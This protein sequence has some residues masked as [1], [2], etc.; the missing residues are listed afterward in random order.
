M[1]SRNGESFGV[2]RDPPTLQ[3][4]DDS[5]RPSVHCH[6]HSLARLH[7]A[8]DHADAIAK[9]PNRHRAVHAASVAHEATHGH[10]QSPALRTS[11]LPQSASDFSGV[12]SSRVGPSWTCRRRAIRGSS[13]VGSNRSG[14][15][16]GHQRLVLVDSI[17]G[18]TALT[19]DQGA[20]RFPHARLLIHVPT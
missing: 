12:G 11:R 2:R 10:N 20:R 7:A 4:S 9:L 1:K 18:E 15:Q 5:D 3:G 19:W 14:A 8:Q 6:R 17:D 13:G 16:A